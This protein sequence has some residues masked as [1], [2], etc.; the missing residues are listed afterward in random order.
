[1]KVLSNTLT[2]WLNSGNLVWISIAC[3]IIC[4]V[5]CFSGNPDPRSNEDGFARN[6]ALLF[7]VSMAALAEAAKKRNRE[8][9]KLF[10]L[11]TG[12]G[13]AYENMP[14]YVDFYIAL[15]ILLTSSAFFALKIGLVLLATLLFVA[16]L[17]ILFIGAS[18]TYGYSMLPTIG[19]GDWIIIERRFIIRRPIKRGDII[20]FFSPPGLKIELP[21]RLFYQNSKLSPG[22]SLLKR[23]VALPGE[24]VR[25][26]HGRVYI[27]DQQ[28]EE[29]QNIPPAAYEINCLGDLG[30]KQFKPYSDPEYC[31]KPTVVPEGHYF[32]LGDFRINENVDSHIFGFVPEKQVIGRVLTSL[33]V[34]AWGIKIPRSDLYMLL[35][36]LQAAKKLIQEK[37]F[38][39]TIEE[40]NKAIAISDLCAPAFAY[41]AQA[42]YS[43]QQLTNAIE[44]CN[45]A[46]HL[47]KTTK[48]PLAGLWEK[49]ALPYLTRCTIYNQQKKY[50]EALRDCNKVINLNAEDANVYIIR[51][52]IFKEM[53]KYNQA[54]QD[55]AHALKI[56]P[57]SNLAYIVQ[58]GVH[59]LTNN[60]NGIL[61]DCSKAEKLGA[62]KQVTYFLRAGAYHRLNRYQDAYEECT[63]FMSLEESAYNNPEYSKRVY[64]LRGATC[65]F[66]KKW[67]EAIEDLNKAISMESN[68][69]TD[70]SNRAFAYFEVG[71]YDQ[72]SEDC[73][74]G[75]RAR[76]GA[77]SSLQKQSA[78]SSAKK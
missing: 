19:N 71:R 49:I 18:W 40:C 70:F 60:F 25:I 68:S 48:D 72:S 23:V 42:K 44:D 62:P 12:K 37:K 57:D 5:A 4:A 50:N 69:A 8:K 51:A 29:D 21:K 64:G 30:N 66:L 53:K 52:G 33:A 34:G 6:A 27:N 7:V 13:G 63:R 58:A 75:D 39:E 54:L 78:H 28:L 36:H 11:T 73:Q 76:S 26:N 15:A 74:K 59:L 61:S 16:T 55:C 77:R 46:I 22:R 32:V 3:S 14:S 47:Y 43:L 38:V 9:E 20:C 41:R 67:T 17:M 2:G 65:I 45:Q 10:E 1:M 31:N 35:R 56:A 24:T